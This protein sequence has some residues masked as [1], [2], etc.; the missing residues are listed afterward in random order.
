MKRRFPHPL[1]LLTLCIFLVAG[2]SYLIPAGEFDRKTDPKTNREVVVAGTYH[3]T[4]PAPVNFW[5]AVLSI[6]RGMQDAASVIFLVFISGAAFGLVDQTGA[7]RWGATRLVSRLQNQRIWVLPLVMLFFGIGSAFINIQEEIIP[8]VPVM[9]LLTRRMGYDRI[10]AVAVSIGAAAIGAAFSPYNPFQAIIAQKIADVPL[11]SGMYFR[12]IFMALALA[13]WIFW[14]IRYAQRTETEPDLSSDVHEGYSTRHA[15]VL[16]LV[17]AVLG[18]YVVG[19]LQFD[20]GFDELAG[21]YFLLGI[22]AAALG[23][24]SMKD[25]T[26]GFIKGL[27]SMAFA[28]TLIGFA[29]AI[30]V[31]M[32]QGHIIDTI[33]NGLF[34]PI[35]HLPVQISALVMMVLQ[36]ALHFVVPSVS[37]QAVLTMPVLAPL[38]DLLGMS[39]NV[40]IMAYHYGAGLAE[41]LVPT[42]GAL[43]AILAAS[44]VRFED[45][46][47][48]MVKPLVGLLV[49]S[50]AALLIGTLIGV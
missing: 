4:P 5:Q 50:G 11:L 35:G 14:V 32:D 24:L 49:I 48:F 29:R 23:R 3:T 27:E 46:I 40:T 39:R 36:G 26:D 16:L 10:V 43:M 34:A 42:N 41:L 12:L 8:L 19:I 33:V 6:P 38:S 31:V 18:T 44:G 30:Y 9:L 2:L 45:W 21:L 47:R 1:V 25:T 22:S 37:G 28:G 15:L 13:F 7:L 20:W 17:L